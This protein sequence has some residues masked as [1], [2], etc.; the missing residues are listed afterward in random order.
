MRT[1]PPDNKFTS[2]TGVP[3]QYARLPL[4]PYGTRGVKATWRATPEFQAKIEAAFNEL[5]TVCPL[6]EAELIV[7]AGFWVEKPGMHGLGRATDLDSIWWKDRTFV[8]KAEWETGGKTFYLAVEAILHKHF[9][10]VLNYSYNIAHHDHFHIDDTDPPGFAR[11]ARSECNF[12]QAA[13]NYVLDIPT[14]ITGQ[15]DNQF[16]DSLHQA[17]V[18]DLRKWSDWKAFLDRVAIVGFKNGT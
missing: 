14:L 15:Y 10:V 16:R 18:G 3:V 7:S 13:L 5:W 8:T 1:A 11:T 17:N 9:G 12:A 4:A 6:G 2:L